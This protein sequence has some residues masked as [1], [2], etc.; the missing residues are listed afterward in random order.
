VEVFERFAPN[1]TLGFGRELKRSRICSSSF[2]S[3]ALFQEAIRN[4]M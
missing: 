3:V 2:S 4:T 1:F